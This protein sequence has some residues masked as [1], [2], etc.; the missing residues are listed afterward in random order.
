LFRGDEAEYRRA[1]GVLLERA[2]ASAEPRHWEV[3]GRTCLLLPGSEAELRRATA[4]VD[5]AIATQRPGNGYYAYFMAAKALAE[6]RAGHDEV[7]IRM[8]EGDAAP[9]LGPMPQLVV[10]MA[11]W[12][13]GQAAEARLA[14]VRAVLS[15]DW[16]PARA[17]GGDVWMYHALRR[18][19][20]AMILPDLPAFLAGRYE[21]RD[22]VERL[23]LTGACQA[24]ELHAAHARLWADAFAADPSLAQ[25]GRERAVVA[26]VLAG[27]GFGKDAAAVTDEDRVRWRAKARAWFGEELAVAAGDAKSDTDRAA[28]ARSRATLSAWRNSPDLAAVR[29]PAALARLPAPEQ[30]AWSALWARAASV[31]GTRR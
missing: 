18:E 27:C 31:V 14:L 26:A 8:M 7:A 21:P 28:Q 20:E 9:V 19:A 30:Q 3:M 12:H 25:A 24:R 13:L 11:R 2:E 6:Y 23:A 5:R 22:D 10:A 1:R 16:T 15:Q 4:L 29:D 17:E